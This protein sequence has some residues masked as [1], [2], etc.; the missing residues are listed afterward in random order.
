LRNK[1]KTRHD[2]ARRI[3]MNKI[4]LCLII[5]FA[6]FTQ[7]KEPPQEKVATLL[8]SLHEK[9]LTVNL[10]SE[11]NHSITELHKLKNRKLKR[12]FTRMV[13]R[14]HEFSLFKQWL[15]NRFHPALEKSISFEECVLALYENFKPSK[16]ILSELS[17]K[18]QRI[19]SPQKISWHDYEQSL[20]NFF[21]SSPISPGQ[22]ED[23]INKSEYNFQKTFHSLD[24]Y[25]KLAS[26]KVMK[27]L[28]CSLEKN[29]FDHQSS[30]KQKE[31]REQLVAQ[32][33]TFE[34]KEKFL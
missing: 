7:T 29:S 8:I 16:H 32:Y 10:S 2:E 3:E 24:K 18:Q 20:I 22:K 27:M 26:L 9:A 33:A 11:W 31:K 30:L 17:Y 4:I 12:R 1:L 14:M 25:A 28:L 15:K 19:L 13:S 6:T 5:I 34:N 21:L 23:G